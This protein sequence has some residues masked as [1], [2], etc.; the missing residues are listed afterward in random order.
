MFSVL[1]MSKQESREGELSSIFIK[2]L[3]KQGTD[4]LVIIGVVILLMANFL[5]LTAIASLGAIATLIVTM[6]VHIGHYK[7]IKETKASKIGILFAI[8]SNLTAIVLFLAYS[9]HQGQMSI[10]VMI[11]VLLLFCYGFEKFYLRKKA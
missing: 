6:T 5:D 8:F 4:G 10:L 11:S 3:W 2:K 7:I 9:V 1:N